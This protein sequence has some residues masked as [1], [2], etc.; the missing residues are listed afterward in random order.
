MQTDRGEQ[1][2]KESRQRAERGKRLPL[3]DQEGLPPERPYYCR[4]CGKEQRARG[5]PRGW[6]SLG[7]HTGVLAQSRLRLG[8]FCCMSCL[9]QEL[10]QIA[11]EEQYLG[12]Q[13]VERLSPTQLEQVQLPRR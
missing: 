7:R 1:R 6:Y 11:R 4:A 10:H 12:E 5:V 2:A 13:W 8:I 9:R 3:R